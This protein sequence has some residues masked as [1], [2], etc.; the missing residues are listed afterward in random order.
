VSTCKRKLESGYSTSVRGYHF[1]WT[2]PAPAATDTHTVPQTPPTMI[3]KPTWIPQFPPIVIPHLTSSIDL[4]ASPQTY[5]QIPLAQLRTFSFATHGRTVG[6]NPHTGFTSFQPPASSFSDG[7]HAE[8]FESA[9]SSPLSCSRSPSSSSP[10][11]QVYKRPRT[12]RRRLVSSLTISISTTPT[13]TVSAKRH[14]TSPCT[15]HATLSPA[16][17]Q[18]ILHFG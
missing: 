18:V 3:P 4:F 2:R 10:L 5:I 15:S 17:T 13:I 14:G 12:T 6:S 9:L 11:L 8:P 7:T 1:P 16:R